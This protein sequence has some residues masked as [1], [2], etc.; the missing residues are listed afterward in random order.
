MNILEAIAHQEV[1]ARAY[2]LSLKLL[3]DGQS[4]AAMLMRKTASR[5]YRWARE[6][7]NLDE[8]TYLD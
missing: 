4:E 3:E 7:M 1:A 8:R 6:E 5:Q 2:Q